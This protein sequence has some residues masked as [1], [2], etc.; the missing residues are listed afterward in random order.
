MTMTIKS[1]FLH[2]SSRISQSARLFAGALTVATLMIGGCHPSTDPMGQAQ[3][4]VLALS[5]SD[6][7]KVNLT[8]TGLAFS[9]PMVFSLFKLCNL[10]GGLLGGLPAGGNAMF[11]ASASDNT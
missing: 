3:V 7:A 4:S 8:V 5:T 10:W 2:T 11:T 6:V 9:Q 1:K